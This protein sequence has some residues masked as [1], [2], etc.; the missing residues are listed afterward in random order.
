MALSDYEVQFDEVPL[1]KRRLTLEEQK[2]LDAG[3]MSQE[4]AAALCRCSFK[5]RGLA[6]VDITYLV[7]HHLGDLVKAVDLYH[8]RQQGRMARSTL[9]DFA[10]ILA[11]DLPILTSEI[12]SVAAEETGQQDKIA[13][14]PALVQ[15]NALLIISK[16][17]TEEAGGLKN[18]LA[19][20]GPILQGAATVGVGEPGALVMKLL[21]SIGGSDQT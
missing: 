4:D 20:V 8:E 9:A 7:E 12:I 5:V 19:F 1:P 3:E 10:M 17:T 13:K 16:L 2:R 15:I 18:L 11:R 6:L 14:L 21:A